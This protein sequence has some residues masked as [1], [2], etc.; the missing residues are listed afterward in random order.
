MEEIS[1]KAK[2]L[3]II[4]SIAAFIFTFLYLIIPE[5]YASLID[6]LVLTLPE[7]I[8]VKD[9]LKW[10]RKHSKKVIYDLYVVRR[11]NTLAGVVKL[12]ELILARQNDQLTSVMQTNVMQLPAEVKVRV[13]FDLPEWLAY[14]TLPVVDSDGTFLGVIHYETLR[15]MERVNQKSRLPREA[16]I[17]STALGELYQIGLTGLIRSTMEGYSR[18]EK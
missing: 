7:D 9:A 16:I 12:Q 18:Q 15:R 10:V 17:A 5:I 14:H 11:N 3:L 4:D 13:I 2:I 1:N 8:K 6:P